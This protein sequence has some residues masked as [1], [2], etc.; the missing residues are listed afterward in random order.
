MHHGLLVAGL[1]VGQI[2]SV[3]EKRLPQPRHVPVAEYP[4]DGG[5]ETTLR[6]VPFTV[7][8]REV[9]DHR[10]R[11]GQTDFLLGMCHGLLLRLII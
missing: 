11:R 4:E 8:H 5:D 1:M 3:L 9:F 6:A 7:L 2:L 10:L